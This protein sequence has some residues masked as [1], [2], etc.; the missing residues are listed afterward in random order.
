[1]W[2]V[3]AGSSSGWRTRVVGGLV[4]LSRRSA[5]AV[6]AVLTHS[7]GAAACLPVFVIVVSGGAGEFEHGAVGVDPDPPV[8]VVFDQVVPAAE[9]ADVFGGRFCRLVRGDGG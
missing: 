7:P 9:R 8:G 1:M 2:L 6:P 4:M 5:M 3:G